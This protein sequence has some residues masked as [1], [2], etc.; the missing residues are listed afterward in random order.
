MYVLGNSLDAIISGSRQS[1]HYAMPKGVNRSNMK[2]PIVST[3]NNVIT[4]VPSV[5]FMVQS[6]GGEGLQL[7]FG[8]RKSCASVP[9][10]IILRVM[11][12]FPEA[13]L[14]RLP[15]TFCFINLDL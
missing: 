12:T 14:I 11:G 5:G 10:I 15:L 3:I 7:S 8:R 9:S 2:K 1:N 4:E 6:P 13:S